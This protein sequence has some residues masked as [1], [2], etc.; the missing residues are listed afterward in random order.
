MQ[1]DIKQIGFFLIQRIFNQFKL[2]F[3]DGNRIFIGLIKNADNGR[4]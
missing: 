1:K 4:K 3:K 2:L